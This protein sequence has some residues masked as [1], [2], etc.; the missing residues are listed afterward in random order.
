LAKCSSGEHASGNPSVPR[1]V[2]QLF[3]G[4]SL[5]PK[6][7][8]ETDERNIRSS[9]GLLLFTSQQNDPAAWLETGRA[10]ERFALLA[11]A[12]GVKNSFINQPC[13]VPA[14]RAHVQAHVSSNGAFPQLLARFGPGPAMPRSLRR[15]IE[16]VL[17][18]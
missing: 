9:S 10:H 5:N 4:R 18:R 6:T 14:L 15:P 12:M 8:D 16:Q 7:Q 3:I 13:E 1:C 11:T 2:G 17:L